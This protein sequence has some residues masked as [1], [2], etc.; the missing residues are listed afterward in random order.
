MNIENLMIR[1]YEGRV[2]ADTHPFAEPY[3]KHRFARFY[4]ESDWDDT[5]AAWNDFLDSN[6]GV[7]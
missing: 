1:Y 5:R 4:A 7:Q 3:T 6:G 2:F